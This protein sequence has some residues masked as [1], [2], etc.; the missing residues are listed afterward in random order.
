MITQ[1][2]VPPGGDT[3]SASK[4]NSILGAIR[5]GVVLAKPA[6]QVRDEIDRLRGMGLHATADTLAKDRQANTRPLPEG[7]KF[8]PGFNTDILGS[9]RSMRTLEMHPDELRDLLV[10]HAQGDHGLHAGRASNAQAIESGRGLVRSRYEVWRAVI[11]SPKHQDTHII[12]AGRRRNQGEWI[13]F[14]SLLSPGG[15][16]FT[17]V[18][19]SLDNVV[20]EL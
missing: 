15:P 2:S 3:Y 9:N 20:G 8:D 16:P 11:D 4:I 6:D 12:P 17:I 19:A 7:A 10:R 14:V 13:E 18:I 1:V 5:M